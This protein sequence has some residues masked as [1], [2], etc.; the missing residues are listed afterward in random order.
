MPSPDSG[1]VRYAD[2]DGDGKSL[3]EQYIDDPGDRRITGNTTP[4]YS[5]VLLL[6]QLQNFDLM[7]SFK[8]LQ[9]KP[10]QIII[11]VNIVLQF[12]LGVSDKALT[13]KQPC[14]NLT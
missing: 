9:A 2:L 5:S 4:R 12:C 13:H 14:G 3:G 11:Q 1:D 8:A 7:R 10:P 6:L